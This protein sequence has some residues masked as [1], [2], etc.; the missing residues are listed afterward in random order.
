MYAVTR[1]WDACTEGT[2]PDTG[3]S[4]F[5]VLSNPLFQ[6]IVDAGLPACAIR[7]EVGKHIG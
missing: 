6:G 5:T 4:A 2:C 7:R 3:Q 1:L